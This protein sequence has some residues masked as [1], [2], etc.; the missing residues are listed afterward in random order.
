MNTSTNN[1]PIRDDSFTRELLLLADGQEI[2][3]PRE[4]LD[5]MRA[6]IR[7]QT[8]LA[9]SITPARAAGSWTKRSW[10]AAAGAAAAVLMALFVFSMQASSRAWAQVVETVRAMP[11]VHMKSHVEGA[12]LAEALAEAELRN[13]GFRLLETSARCA[14][15]N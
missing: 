4:L 13:R 11:W 12:G 1:D 10:F 9:A 7:E 3:P 15:T 5:R 8:V 2:E 14:A 6:K